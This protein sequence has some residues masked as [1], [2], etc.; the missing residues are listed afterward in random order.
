[1]ELDEL[2]EIWKHPS[3]TETVWSATELLEALQGKSKSILSRIK[4]SIQIEITTGG[5]AFAILVSQIIMVEP[6]PIWWLMI[7]LLVFSASVAIYFYLKIR[8]VTTF[9]F[10]TNNLK[11]NLAVL[12]N[13]L[14]LFL[15]IYKRGNQWGLVVFYLLGLTAAYLEHGTDRV[16]EYITTAQGALLVVL[17][18]AA[19]IGP[20][21]FVDRVLHKLYG[22]HIHRLKIM[23]ADFDNPTDLQNK[24]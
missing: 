9:D 12:I 8:L 23:L 21:F 5:I 1:M 13:K 16:L 15:K 18:T 2:K 6:G 17:Y 4:R 20:V 11:N 10:S 19:I 3:A 24:A 14:E 22:E 7:G